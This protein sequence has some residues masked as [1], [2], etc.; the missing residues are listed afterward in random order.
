MAHV[1]Y[2]QGSHLSRTKDQRWEYALYF[3]LIFAISL[4]PAV[5]RMVVPRKGQ[6]RRFFVTAAWAMAQEVTPRIFSV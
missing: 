3:V 2:D 6:A 4:P 5:V 1:P